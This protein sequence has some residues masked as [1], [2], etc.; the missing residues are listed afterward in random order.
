MSLDDEVKTTLQ[1]DLR[2]AERLIG[3]IKSKSE[4]AEVADPDYLAP[5]V[6]TKRTVELDDPRGS[7]AHYQNV[8]EAD[9]RGPRDRGN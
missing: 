5:T 2:I 3:S 8:A 6:S 9:C 4:N 1:R 7:L